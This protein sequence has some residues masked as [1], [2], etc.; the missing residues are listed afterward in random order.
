[1]T[2]LQQPVAGR[3]ILFWQ[4]V[5]GAY[6]H[7]AVWREEGRVP[8]RISFCTNLTDQYRQS[9]LERITLEKAKTKQ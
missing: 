5:V 4:H 6:V 3:R 2:Q 9:D 1:M 8:Q 7:L